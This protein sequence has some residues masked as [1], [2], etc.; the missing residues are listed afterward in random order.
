[1]PNYYNCSDGSKVSQATIDKRRSEAYR[2]RYE[3]RP[4]VCRGCGAPATC[5]AHIIAQARA[6]NIGKAELCWDWDNFFPAC[7]VCNGRIENPKGDG[8]KQ[9]LNK[10]EC[11]EVIKKHDSQLYAKFEQNIGHDK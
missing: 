10:E 9:L 4:Q 1:M 8:W 7:Y 5:S 2:Q 6:K 11:L 3:G